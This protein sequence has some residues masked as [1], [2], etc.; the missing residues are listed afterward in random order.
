[1]EHGRTP[2]PLD[3]GDSGAS[4]SLDP[5]LLPAGSAR[6]DPYGQ[7]GGPLDG[8]GQ[9]AGSHAGEDSDAE[10]LKR[11]EFLVRLGQA[12]ELTRQWT[13]WSLKGDV[14]YAGFDDEQRAR[15]ATRTDMRDAEDDL[16]WAMSRFAPEIRR[17]FL[18]QVIL[19]KDV[20]RDVRVV[21]AASVTA[22][23]VG[24]TRAEKFLR[25]FAQL[26]DWA[27]REVDGFLNEVFSDDRGCCYLV[28]ASCYQADKGR[29]KH[30]ARLTRMLPEPMRSLVGL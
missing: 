26:P 9:G 28:A 20:L 17:E 16:V 13:Q 7:A 2:H 30:G 25:W 18:R 12:E 29:K 19:V 15:I 21:T 14:Y 11:E 8:P 3:R 4:G 27:R 24:R 23:P 5:A 10:Q 22:D 6:G 1:M